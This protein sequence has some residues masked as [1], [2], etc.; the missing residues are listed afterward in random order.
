ME[1]FSGLQKEIQDELKR[2][3][4]RHKSK[5]NAIKNHNIKPKRQKVEDGKLSDG[6]K[7]EEELKTYR[8]RAVER[9]NDIAVKSIDEYVNEMKDHMSSNVSLRSSS[10]L[11]EFKVKELR[12][13]E[14]N[15]KQREIKE[16]LRLVKNTPEKSA[17]SIDNYKYITKLNIDLDNLN[18]NEEVV[19]QRELVEVSDGFFYNLN[20]Q[21]DNNLHLPISLLSKISLALDKN[22]H[23]I[24]LVNIVEEDTESI[25]SEVSDMFGNL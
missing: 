9:L 11:K 5:R 10:V 6:L 16:L 21:K 22:E 17:T 7:K 13:L 23:K 24:E 15:E 19:F 3:Q 1:K 14:E 18:S 12:S 20:Q 4:N 25:S 8:D 2:D